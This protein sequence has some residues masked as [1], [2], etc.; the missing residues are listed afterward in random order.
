VTS[1]QRG[2]NFGSVE[3]AHAAAKP[4]RQRAEDQSDCPEQGSSGDGR[5]SRVCCRRC[6]PLRLVDELP[7]LLIELRY[8]AAGLIDANVWAFA[9]ACTARSRAAS[10]PAASLVTAAHTAA[11]AASRKAAASVPPLALRIDWSIDANP[12][13]RRRYR[14]GRRLCCRTQCLRGAPKRRCRVCEGPPTMA[15]TLVERR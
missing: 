10:C 2:R 5:S 13:Q 7:V 4:S 3:C 11:V 14:L 8:L 9:N 15:P 1:P 12:R 6:L